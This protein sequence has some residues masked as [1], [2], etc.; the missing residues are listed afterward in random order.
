[1]SEILVF[2]DRDDV[3][4]ELLS[5]GREHKDSLGAELAAAVLGDRAEARAND[6]FTHGA[7]KVYLAKDDI[8]TEF[9]TDVFAEAL[10]QIARDYQVELLLIGSTRRGKE[11]APRIAQKWGAGCVTD[12]INVNL[13]DGEILIDRYSLGGN[14]IASAFI[15]TPKK[16][17]SVMPKAFALGEK[18]A[19]KGEVIN[20]T[21][22]LKEPRLKIEERREKKGESV[23]LEDAEALVCVGR[24]LS[25]REDISLIEKLAKALNAEIGCTRPLSHDWQWFSEEREVGLSGKK[26]KPRLCVSI[27][28]S[29]QIQHTVG[30]RDSKIIVAINKDK[31]APIFT[32]AD[33]GIVSDLY[34]VV[35]KIIDRI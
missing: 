10:Y 14:T 29:G 33:Y 24:G 16:V 35:P 5:W 18:E 23:N 11:L 30:I 25:K 26:C 3:A 8:L 21:L 34:E 6:Y 22:K 4:F 19:K 17:I 13:K 9:H 20:V 32:V 28:I 15:T 2:C 1:M 12:A 27:G 31:N 7:D